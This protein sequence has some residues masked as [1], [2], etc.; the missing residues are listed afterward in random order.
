MNERPNNLNGRRAGYTGT[1]QSSSFDAANVPVH[2]HDGGSLLRCNAAGG[3]QIVALGDNVGPGFS[4]DVMAEG[5][6]TVRI[7]STGPGITVH[8]RGDR[9]DLAGQYAIAHAECIEPGVWVVS[10]DLITGA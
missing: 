7:G 5:T 8:S 1:R 3:V 4:I 6:A 2:E 9:Y 10:G